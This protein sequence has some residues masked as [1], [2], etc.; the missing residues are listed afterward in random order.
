MTGRHTPVVP[1]TCTHPE[2]PR[3]LGRRRSTNRP[4]GTVVLPGPME[5]MVKSK[6]IAGV[7][8]WLEQADEVLRDQRERSLSPS[9]APVWDTGAVERTI[10]V[11]EFTEGIED[12]LGALCERPG[13]WILIV[14]CGPHRYWQALAFEDGSL[15][16]E[17]ISNHWIE[18]ED[19]LTP[20]QEE[21]LCDL[22]WS[23]PEPPRRPN[24]T[25]VE[26]TTSP[27]VAGAARQAAETLR[28]VFGAE[29]LDNIG[30]KLFSSSTRGGTPA[31]P[32][33]G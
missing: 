21:R 25:R 16:T 33:Y 13:R 26:P 19:R 17:V 12:V 5:V 31:C 23:S 2:E 8:G 29:G 24:W 30:M 6:T 28:Q 7:D 1:L 9:S 20:G 11:T 22:G 15:V 3:H 27:D 32:T 4:S 18:G 10:T 14:E